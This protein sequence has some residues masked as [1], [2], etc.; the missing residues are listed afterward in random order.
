MVATADPRRR[1][2]SKQTSST[3]SPL[4]GHPTDGRRRYRSR[5]FGTP[6][7]EHVSVNTVQCIGSGGIIIALSASRIAP[8]RSTAVAAH[9]EEPCAASLRGVEQPTGRTYRTVGYIVVPNSGDAVPFE[10]FDR[11]FDAIALLGPYSDQPDSLS[12]LYRGQASG[13][14]AHCFRRAFQ[15]IAM[16]LPKLRLR[17]RGTS[18]AQ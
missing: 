6:H 9:D 13:E 2:T 10:V 14:R 4:S 16:V 8:P 11:G 12:T 1:S 15:A 7:L 3:E 5:S 17:G 18:T